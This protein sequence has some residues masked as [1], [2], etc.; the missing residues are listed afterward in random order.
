MQKQVVFDLFN[1]TKCGAYYYRIC[2]CYLENS[3]WLGWKG[4]LVDRRH[5]K[6]LR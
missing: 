2:W 1:Y 5:F 6:D 4:Y 3:D